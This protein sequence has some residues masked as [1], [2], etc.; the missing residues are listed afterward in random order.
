MVRTDVSEKHTASVS[1]EG[2]DGDSVLFPNVGTHFKEPRDNR[3]VNVSYLPPR[4]Q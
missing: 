2:K 3:N 1:R 4:N